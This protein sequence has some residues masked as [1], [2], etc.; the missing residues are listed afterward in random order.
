MTFSQLF[1]ELKVRFQLI[2][3]PFLRTLRVLRSFKKAY[4]LPLFDFSGNTI[5]VKGLTRPWFNYPAIEFLDTIDFNGLNVFEYGCGNSTKYFS[6]SGASVYG[7][8]NDLKWAQMVAAKTGSNILVSN[9]KKEYINSVETFEMKF[10]V[11]VIDGLFRD[12][13][14]ELFFTR[15]NLLESSVL[16][17]DNS[18]WFPKSIKRVSNEED[19]IPIY[20]NGFG[21]KVNYPTQTLFLF[22][23]K[24][25]LKFKIP[26][27]PIG[28]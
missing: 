3:D 6:Q 25:K 17:F 19:W 13:C 22:N 18:N 27:S 8:E 23:R 12:E 7:V 4:A 20:F 14:C 24:H 11:V 26:E 10:D 16:I 1:I 15:Q 5:E 21:P 2:S 9:E 28:S